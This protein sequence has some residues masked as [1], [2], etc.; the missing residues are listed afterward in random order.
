MANPINID[1]YAVAHAAPQ[2]A[3]QGPLIPDL[4]KVVSAYLPECDALRLEKCRPGSLFG[5]RTELEIN[6]YN[7]DDVLEAIP[8]NKAGLAA[9]RSLKISGD[10]YRTQ[11]F[12]GAVISLV[13][14]FEGIE[15]LDLSLCRKLSDDDLEAILECCPHLKFL[16]LGSLNAGYT[17]KILLCI[18]HFCPALKSL[19]VRRCENL[20]GLG[21]I[22]L[23]RDFPGL[24]SLD[25]G[26]CN[27]K[28]AQ[29]IEIVK[30]LPGLRSLNLQSS[31]TLTDAGLIKLLPYCAGLQSLN[32]GYCE[33]IT[34]IGLGAIALNCPGLHSLDVSDCNDLVEA[35]VETVAAGY[36]PELRSLNFRYCDRLTQA[37][38]Q[39]LQ[40][41]RPH[42]RIER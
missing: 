7:I 11:E 27:L 23:A 13:Q 1:L 21:L 20:T 16:N 8:A 10:G 14:K 17:D 25:I 29:R 34:Q 38:I 9:I 18:R 32:I 37:H 28:N 22:N 12:S 39:Q 5:Q 26:G 36:W 6:R 2:P 4:L 35:V 19:S 31:Y 3:K 33:R 42:L 24:E 15:H 40:L 30:C 41:A